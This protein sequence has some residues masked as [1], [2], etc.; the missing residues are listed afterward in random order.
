VCVGM[1]VCVGEVY[2]CVHVCVCV[3]VRVC[4]CVLTSFEDMCVCLS[5]DEVGWPGR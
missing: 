4:M 3:H 1:G 5:N 2:V